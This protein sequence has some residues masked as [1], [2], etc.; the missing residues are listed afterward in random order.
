MKNLKTGI[1]YF[2]KYS[3]ALLFAYTLLKKISNFKLFRIKLLRS[4]IIPD[5]AIDFFAYIIPVVEFIIVVL[6]ASYFKTKIYLYVSLAVLLAFTFYLFAI[7]HFSLY[8]GCSCGGVF[9]NL[10]YSQHL[11]VN[12]FFTL[13]NITALSFKRKVY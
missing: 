12:L 4:E 2:C 8:T 7:N 13:L 1:Y 6:L 11:L 9:E 5:Y 3:L 10:T